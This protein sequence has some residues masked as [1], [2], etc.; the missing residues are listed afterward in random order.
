M[1]NKKPSAGRT[2]AALTADIAAA[3]KHADSAKNAAK[4]AKA[5]YHEA[6]ETFKMARRAAKS[7]KKAV[8]KLKSARVASPVRKRTPKSSPAS[9]NVVPEPAA[10]AS[11][12][13][14]AMPGL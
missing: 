13:T 6:K 4:V 11:A 7:A 14:T 2:K 10:P 8:K 5:A 9:Q 1:K 12:P 3:Q